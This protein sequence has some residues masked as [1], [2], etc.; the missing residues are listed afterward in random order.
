MYI[1]KAFIKGRSLF[2]TPI[3]KLPAVYSTHL[4]YF[5]DSRKLTDGQ[6]PNDRGCY[7]CGKIGHR[8]KEC[9]KDWPPRQNVPATAGFRPQRV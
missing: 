1:M 7:R 2:G 8:V 5:F 9:P 6:R 4:D 3:D